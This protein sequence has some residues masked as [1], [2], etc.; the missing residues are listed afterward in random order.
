MKLSQLA[1]AAG[2]TCSEEAEITGLACRAEEVTPGALF[3]ALE[4]VR[5]NGQDYIPE[6]VKRGAAA[7]LCKESR[8]AHVPVLAAEEPRLALAQIAAEFFGR[9]GDKMKLIAVT[10]TKG[11]TTTAHMLREIL[12]AAGYTIGMIGTLGGYINRR[13]IAPGLNTTPEPIAL[14]KM[15]GQ[16]AAEGCTYVV[17]EASSQGVKQFRTAGLT[18]DI[19]VFLN[20]SP[21]HIGP[22]EHESY[23][24]YR[25][26][27]ASLFRQCRHGIGNGGDEAWPIMAAELP[28]GAAAETFI[29]GVVSPRSDLTIDVNGYPVSMP[30]IFNGQNA[31]AAIKTAKY[32]GVGENAIRQGLAHI[33]VPGRC[34]V[35]PVR[36]P[37]TVLIDY[38]H[39]GAAMTALLGALREHPHRRIIA[40]FGAGGDRPPMRRWDLGRAAAEGAD[41]AVLTEDNPRSERGEDI[42]RQIGEA[43]PDLPHVIIPDRKQ[44]IRFALDMAQP[45]D[46]VALL[47][48]GHEEYIERNGV[49]EYFSEQAVVE[50]YFREK[51]AA[52]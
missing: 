18:F 5:S 47:G 42:C 50:E 49:R 23:E 31:L 22:G 37:Y 24:E 4:G 20:L 46:I 34:M 52:R 33:R 51:R 3:V 19:G 38:A 11:K 25:A 6:A 30:G 17:T 13:Q 35:C 41:F 39:N 9:P 27:K 36:A 29:C 28:Q 32:L 43:M 48:K 45:G 16:M 26:C 15:L 1:R 8:S 12:V 44:A 40:V 2:L 14:H 7:V 10:G 21:D